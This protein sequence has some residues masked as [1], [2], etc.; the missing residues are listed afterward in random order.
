MVMRSRII[1]QECGMR[2]AQRALEVK[3]EGKKTL[4]IP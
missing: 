3:H 1:R 2:D 4:G